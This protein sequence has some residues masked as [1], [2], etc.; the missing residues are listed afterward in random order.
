MVYIAWKQYSL[1]SK[2]YHT[3]LRFDVESLKN[4]VSDCGSII[5]GGPGPI[6]YP[7]EY[8]TLVNYGD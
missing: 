6:E 3:D 4:H 7:T 8:L 2:K 1:D 5:T